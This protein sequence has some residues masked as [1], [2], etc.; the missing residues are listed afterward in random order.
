MFK[1]FWKD[2]SGATTVDWVVITA[3]TVGLGI[4][5]AGPVSSG[6]DSQSGAVGTQ[7]SGQA[8]STSFGSSASTT[9]WSGNSARYYVDYGQSLAPGNNG[10]IYA[11]AQDMAASEAPSGYNFD[12]PLVDVASGN[13]VYTSNDGLTYSV[14]GEVHPVDSFSG[15]VQPFAA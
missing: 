6:L 4:A 5:T 12:N 8:I 14:G 10:A 9:I 1:N 2:Q 11:H 13:V 15:D 3:A 7:L